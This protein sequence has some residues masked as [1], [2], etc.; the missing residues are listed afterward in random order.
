M[1]LSSQLLTIVT[2][3]AGFSQNYCP[4]KLKCFDTFLV[5]LRFPSVRKGLSEQFYSNILKLML[6]SLLRS[7]M[8]PFTVTKQ[9]KMYFLMLTNGFKWD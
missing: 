8:D 2:I 9:W 6:F 5:F 3:S 4:C 7:Q 1:D